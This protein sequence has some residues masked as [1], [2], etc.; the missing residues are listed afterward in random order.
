MVY[1]AGILIISVFEGKLYTLLGKDH[2]NTY[3]DFG[4]KND[5]CD[6]NN[7]ISTAAREAYEETCGCLYSYYEFSN[8]LQN[9]HNISS[10]SF[11]NKPYHMYILFIKY[12]HDISK[13]YNTIYKYINSLKYFRK[14][15]EKKELKWFLLSD[16]LNNK[17]C[18]RNIF[19]KTIDI[20][21][22]SILKIAYKYIT[23]NTY[24]SYGRPKV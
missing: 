24:Y 10:L 1:A 23:T 21:K 22:N 3:S 19:K 8:K 15:Q 16:V 17:V 11:T 18:L 6:N 12:D 14:F 5:L 13:R 9:C 4:G 7:S 20:H 2:Y